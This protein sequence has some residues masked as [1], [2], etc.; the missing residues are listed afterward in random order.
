MA[1]KAGLDA[2]TIML[3]ARHLVRCQCQG[4]VV[5]QTEPSSEGNSLERQW[6]GER[7]PEGHLCSWQHKLCLR[8]FTALVWGGSC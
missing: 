8:A 2:L 7:P 4:N 1:R 6:V 3:Q 5:Q